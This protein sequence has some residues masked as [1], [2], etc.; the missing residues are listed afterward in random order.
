M[1]IKA[2]IATATAQGLALRKEQEEAE[3]VAYREKANTYLELNLGNKVRR[4][5]SENKATVV[6]AEDTSEGFSL[7][8]SNILREA[9]YRVSLDKSSSDGDVVCP[10][11]CI[12]SSSMD[13]NWIKDTIISMA[14]SAQTQRDMQDVDKEIALQ[15]K[16][17][18]KADKFL[19]K[20]LA[21]VIK[22]GVLSRPD[23]NAPIPICDVRHLGLAEE[24]QCQLERAGFK[25][26]L[27]HLEPR[28]L[29]DFNQYRVSLYLKD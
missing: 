3:R 29:I 23:K 6:L 2:V 7:A 10:S 14:T 4:A 16:W 24:I 21:R 19:S 5:V 12:W 9:G 22:R 15:D 8:V 1:D 20:N 13:P 11:P 27:T 26:V 17:G 18:P 28:S 25:T